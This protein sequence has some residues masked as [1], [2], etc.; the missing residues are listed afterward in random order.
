MRN[1]Q[2]FTLIELLVVI[3]I[4]AILIAL[5]LPAVQ[6]VR[7]AADRITCANNLKQIGLAA[8]NYHD[9]EGVLPAVSVMRQGVQVWWAPY[10][11]RVGPA[12]PPLPDY[13]P[14]KALLWPYIE[15][16]R[17]VFICPQGFL[18]GTGSAT[19]QHVQVSYALNGVTG[20]PS[21]M[22]LVALDNGTSN[23]LLGWDHA[24]LPGC[25]MPSGANA[26]ILV[27]VPFDAPDAPVHYPPRHSRLFNTVY[28]DGHVQGMSIDQLA[29]PLFLA[30]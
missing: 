13:D 27:P 22:R 15:G 4:I 29:V 28:C 17:K 21:G 8:H 20:G 14:T 11:S 6:K 10:D 7:A 16:Q 12:D 19:L 18:Q 2:A 30:R 3:A 5:L 24:N 25:S 1:R 23:I 26:N 9:T